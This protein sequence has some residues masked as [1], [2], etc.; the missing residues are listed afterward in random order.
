MPMQPGR[1]KE[2]KEERGRDLHPC[3][4]AEGAVPGPGE[5]TFLMGR[6]AGTEGS[7]ATRQDRV[8]P[9]RTVCV[10]ALRLPD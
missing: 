7:A 6:S 10:T 2:S 4:G 1:T 9:A 3:G 8:R 5:P